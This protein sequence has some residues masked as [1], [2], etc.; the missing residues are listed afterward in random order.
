MVVL[1][2]FVSEALVIVEY[3]A[4]VGSVTFFEIDRFDIDVP[5]RPPVHEKVADFVPSALC[6]T[7]NVCEI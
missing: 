5:A 1:P 7:V 6:E 4:I 2:K 3:L